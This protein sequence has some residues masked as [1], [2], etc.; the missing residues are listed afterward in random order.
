MKTGVGIYDQCKDEILMVIRPIV[1]FFVDDALDE[2]KNMIGMPYG[3]KGLLNFTDQNVFDDGL[4]C[5]QVGC[6]FYR[7]GKME[8]F[9]H[10][11]LTR[12]VSPMHFL[13]V[14]SNVFDIVYLRP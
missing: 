1:P 4:F 12:R 6:T 9:N 7:L 3:T 2:F 5:S 13:Y 10:T 14:S 11:V 8:P